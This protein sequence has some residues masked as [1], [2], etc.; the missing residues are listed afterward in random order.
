VAARLPV[1]Q[2]DARRENEDRPFRLRMMQAMVKLLIVLLLKI[3]YHK[4]CLKGKNKQAYT[5]VIA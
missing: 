4:N 2:R 1:R 3:A 5:K